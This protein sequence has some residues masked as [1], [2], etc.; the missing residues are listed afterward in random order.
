MKFIVLI[1][2]LILNSIVQAN[3][4]SSFDKTWCGSSRVPVEIVTK[5]ANN[6]GIVTKAYIVVPSTLQK[7]VVRNV[8]EKQMIPKTEEGLILT[9]KGEANKEH[10]GKIYN[11]DEDANTEI[12]IP[13][14]FIN[15]IST[16]GTNFKIHL[17]RTFK[18]KNPVEFSLNPMADE[19][20]TNLCNCQWQMLYQ[21]I[22]ENFESRKSFLASIA[23]AIILSFS[24]V[25]YYT[26]LLYKYKNQII[27]KSRI[28]QL[29][30]ELEIIIQRCTNIQIEISSLETT[31]KQTIHEIEIHNENIVVKTGEIQKYEKNLAAYF[32]EKER[33]ETEIKDENNKQV[34]QMLRY[35]LD[36]SNVLQPHLDEKLYDIKTPFNNIKKEIKDF[37]NFKNDQTQVRID[38][39]KNQN[40]A[41]L[42]DLEKINIQLNAN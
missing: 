16:I 21:R 10:L 31:L 39:L 40:N 19:Y 41:V 3:S 28:T 6:V 24:N 9:L 27:D 33:V 35:L 7:I 23:N 25:Q 38:N 12:Y 26:D 32:A 22:K 17:S 5:N 14:L 11:Y 34:D 13:Y 36:A 29:K 18:D 20:G 1:S 2:L 8:A 15:S 4:Q 30:K 42:S 37:E